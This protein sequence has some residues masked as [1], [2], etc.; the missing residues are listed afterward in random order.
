[1]RLFGTSVSL[2]V[3]I[4]LFPASANSAAL[5]ENFSSFKPIRWSYITFGSPGPFTAEFLNGELH[6]K[7]E[8]VSGGSAVKGGGLASQFSISGDFRI[9]VKFRWS[10]YSNKNQAQL[11]ISDTSWNFLYD[12][13]NGKGVDVPSDQIIYYNFVPADFF[14]QSNARV[15]TSDTEGWFRLERTG[16]I[17]TAFYSSDGVSFV[18]IPRPVSVTS[19]DVRFSLILQNN[20]V[21]NIS[22]V[23]FDNLEVIADGFTPEDVPVQ[24]TTWGAVKALYRY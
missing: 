6:L 4:C 23:F 17:F 19:E 11:N 8:T 22:E 1:M 16:A 15:T 24:N 12:M 2:L 13:G 5:F 3:F 21:D 10:I 18:Q 14:I 9:T 20:N 7:K